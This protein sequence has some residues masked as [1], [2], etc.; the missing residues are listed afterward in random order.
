MHNIVRILQVLCVII[1][2]S[3]CQRPLRRRLHAGLI[4]R[5]GR[6]LGRNI[7]TG[8]NPDRRGNRVGRNRLRN[9]PQNTPTHTL[10]DSANRPSTMP[11][12]ILPSRPNPPTNKP[13]THSKSSKPNIIYIMVD[14]LGWNDIGYR[15]NTDIKTP[16]LTKLATN[17]GVRLENYYTAPTCGPT[18]AQF[19]SGKWTKFYLSSAGVVVVDDI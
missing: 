9:G 13:P 5:P 17:K 7:G 15:P 3:D 16:T 11:N 10:P 6:N 12:V 19:L 4:N 18:R 2:R 8:R 1:Q 14:D